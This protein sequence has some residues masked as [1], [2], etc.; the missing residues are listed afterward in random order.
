MEQVNSLLEIEN[1]IYAEPATTGQRFANYLVDTIVMYI[2]VILLTAGWMIA[3]GNYTE[4]RDGASLLLDYL[5]GFLYYVIYYTLIEGLLKGRSIGKFITGTKVIKEDGSPIGWGEAFKRSLCRIV[6]FEPFS[7]FGGYPWH[8][9][10]THT[11]V[12]KVKK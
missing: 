2:I 7:A 5:K 10:W 9:R 1:E 6:P 8:D 12:V 3:T 4:P 11:K